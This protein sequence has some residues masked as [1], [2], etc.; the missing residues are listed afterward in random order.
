MCAC[1][2]GWHVGVPGTRGF[3]L[4][5]WR[6]R[7]LFSSRRAPSRGAGALHRCLPPQLCQGSREGGSLPEPPSWGAG[8][9]PWQR[10]CSPLWPSRR[11]TWSG[12]RACCG[13]VWHATSATWGCTAVCGSRRL[14]RPWP[15]ILRLRLPLGDASST[16]CPD[17]YFVEGSEWEAGATKDWAQ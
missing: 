11:E 1:S 7:D 2:G 5:S 6:E 13:V 14:L 4:H 8:Y 17:R 15:R 9:G 10:A 16:F 12:R 3:T